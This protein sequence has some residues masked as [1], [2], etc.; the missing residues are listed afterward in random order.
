MYS[1]MKILSLI[2]LTRGTGICQYLSSFA[3]I[4]RENLMI[5]DTN[6][7]SVLEELMG[8]TDAS[9]K[10]NRFAKYEYCNNDNIYDMEIFFCRFHNLYGR[11]V[12]FSEKPDVEHVNNLAT[13]IKTQNSL[14][15]CKYLLVYFPFCD[16]LN[17][18]QQIIS[19]S[20]YAVVFS[21]GT[22]EIE[23]ELVQHINTLPEKENCVG[24]VRTKADNAY[25]HFT[26][27]ESLQIEPLGVLPYN[28]IIQNAT[29]RNKVFL[30]IDDQNEQGKTIRA[31]WVKI[32]SRLRA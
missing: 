18:I 28:L 22:P 11:S 5:L 23:A 20:D 7:Y 4:E 6:Q 1:D 19:N 12:Q 9:V 10:T 21:D 2:E 17:A 32:K 13:Y 8:I 14:K 3:M 31:V 29:I 24:L 26:E 30:E 25:A 15:N 16:D 27:L